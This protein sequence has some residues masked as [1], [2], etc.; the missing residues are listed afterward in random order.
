MVI[1]ILFAVM[2]QTSTLSAGQKVSLDTPNPGWEHT[3][4]KTGHARERNSV[5]YQRYKTND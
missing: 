5:H 3:T 1:S 4:S 2:R